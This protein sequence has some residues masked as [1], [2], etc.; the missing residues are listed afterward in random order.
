MDHWSKSSQHIHIHIHTY[1]YV[2]MLYDPFRY[3]SVVT[4]SLH[5]HTHT[6]TH[7]YTIHSDTS[8]TSSIAR[9]SVVTDSL[10]I[11]TH[12]YTHTYTIHSD[13]SGTSS[14]ARTS[15]VTDS[16]HI[17]TH[18]HTYI[19]YTF[20][21][22]WY[23]LDRTHQRGDGIV[24]LV[25]HGITVKESRNIIFRDL[26]DRVAMFLRL[27]LDT[28]LHN[29][30]TQHD[31]NGSNNQAHAEVYLVNT[32]LIF[33][34]QPHFSVI[35][36][37]ELRKILGF[38]ELYIRSQP[39]APESPILLCG[40]F[41]GSPHGNQYKLLRLRNFTSSCTDD[42]K[43]VTH[44]NHLGE[45]LCCDYIFSQNPSDRRGPLE[46]NLVEMVFKSTR[47]RI[48]TCA[49]PDG[50]LNDENFECQK[51]PSGTSVAV[52]TS[53]GGNKAHDNLDIKKH[54]IDA[55]D[56][57]SVN[58]S[59]QT[60]IDMY[61]TTNIISS[62]SDSELGTQSPYRRELNASLYRHALNVH[63]FG[64][65]CDALSDADLKRLMEGADKHHIDDDTLINATEA[66]CV[67]DQDSDGRIN[68]AEFEN[69]CGDLELFMGEDEMRRAFVVLD[70][71]HNDY[72]ERDE[73]TRWWVLM[74]VCVCVCVRVFVFLCVPA[75]D[76]NCSGYVECSGFSCAY[77]CVMC[78]YMRFV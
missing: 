62:N 76:R 27:S 25:R 45:T 38:L 18:P 47:Q 36:M 14:I 49:K 65:V 2:Y 4:E 29:N 61:N 66:F 57:T 68:F 23:Q 37:R 60:V 59:I 32:H 15:V 40:D 8:G 33:P 69:M 48:C 16:L 53:D 56:K 73:F 34:H 6:Y 11:H 5:I 63:G 22:Q 54:G 43:W 55:R 52:K 58:I 24:T 1:M 78:A 50:L 46:E 35:R 21:Y 51:V 64:L 10:H 42:T 17:H 31:I 28:Y 26:G 67:F 9:T 70:K 7:T 72:I 13:T 71:N 77:K 19:H 3:T 12:T 30:E 75:C 41:N 74:C 20:R 39:S 44:R